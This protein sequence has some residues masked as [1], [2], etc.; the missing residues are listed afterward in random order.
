MMVESFVV[1]VSRW[2][3]EVRQQLCWGSTVAMKVA[4]DDSIGGSVG[5]LFGGWGERWS[6]WERLY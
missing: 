4:V 3:D 5:G 1:A 6:Q 2:T